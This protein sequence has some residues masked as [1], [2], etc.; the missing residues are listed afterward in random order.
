MGNVIIKA[1]TLAQ[2]KALAARNADTLYFLTDAKK[3]MKGDD[4]YTA[5]VLIADKLPESGQ[6]QGKLYI[7]GTT[8]SVWNGS[9][10]TTVFEQAVI[11]TIIPSYTGTPGPTKSL[12][13][14]CAAYKP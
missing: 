8:G 10:W 1:G 6:I 11:P 13:L 2:Y 7:V 9:A 12:P 3:I 5:S 14:S 4:D